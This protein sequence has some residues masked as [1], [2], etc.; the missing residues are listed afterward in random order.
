ME[1]EYETKALISKEDF[2]ALIKTLD[3]ITIK[4]QSNTYLETKDNFFK[5]KMCAL[6]LRVI[7]N[8]YII[9]LKCSTC[10]TNKEWNKSISQATYKSILANRTI[11]LSLLNCPFKQIVEIDNLITIHTK[12][13]VCLFK[14]NHIELDETNFN[15]TV[16]YEIEVEDDSTKKSQEIFTQLIKEYNITYYQSD[17]KIA[18]YFKYN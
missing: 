16:D 8:Q 11:D 1:Y 4:N 2:Y 13:Y 17:A 3:V 14:T 6:R 18:R 10:D 15:N 5:S 12:R 7:N 9:S